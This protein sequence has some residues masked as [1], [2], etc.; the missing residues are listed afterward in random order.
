MSDDLHPDALDEE[1]RRRFAGGSPASSDP[2]V[3]LDA[4]RPQL[5]RAR[6]RRQVSFASAIAGVAAIVVVLAFVLGSGGGGGGSVRTPPASNGPINTVPPVPT[7]ADVGGPAT[8][9]TVAGGSDRGGLVG[10]DPAAPDAT[11][12]TQPA[13]VTTSGSQLAPAGQEATFSSAGGS[14]VVRLADGAASLVSDS[15]AAGYSA[16]V[17]DNGPSRVEVRFSNGNTEWRIR[18]D[19]VNGQLVSEVT[20]H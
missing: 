5:A 18:V 12:P 9:D 19:V 11:P 8:P 15:P 6:T 3:V 7:T 13:P 4:M 17:H 20:Q 16:E 14:I 10:S 2:D 1:L